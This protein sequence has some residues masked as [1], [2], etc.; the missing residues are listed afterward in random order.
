MTYS[1][2]DRKICSDESEL[3]CCPS[4][5]MVLQA[6]QL[7]VVKCQ[8]YWKRPPL[9]DL[10][11]PGLAVPRDN[12]RREHDAVDAKL[13]RALD[14][15]RDPPAGQISIG[16][17]YTIRFDEQLSTA[18]LSRLRKLKLELDLR[19]NLVRWNKG[20]LAVEESPARF[21]RVTTQKIWLAQ[22]CS[23]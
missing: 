3:G 13:S 23:L 21:K 17:K 1:L 6:D 7:Q 20:Y 8:S 12:A 9:P 18:D 16:G 15:R 14:L 11:Q 4:I 5:M 22:D 10:L 19:W 2:S